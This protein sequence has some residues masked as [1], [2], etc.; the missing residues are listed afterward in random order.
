VLV[1]VLLFLSL[2]LCEIFEGLLHPGHH[3][4]LGELGEHDPVL[5][6]HQP[7]VLLGVAWV[8]GRLLLELRL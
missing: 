1:L 2:H 5:V 3:L 4:F 7:L 6:H 8:V